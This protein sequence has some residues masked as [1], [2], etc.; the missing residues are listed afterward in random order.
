M[1]IAYFSPI[2]PIKSGISAYSE[3]NLLPY[4]S[5][6]CT[7]DLIIDEKF[8]P[9]NE[10]VKKKFKVISYK[11]FM[12][13]LYDVL[14]YHMGNNPYHEYIYNVLLQ[15]PGVVVLHD[16]FIADL[17]VYM[18]IGKQKPESYIEH[19]E[20]C[21]GEKG[22]KIA[23][24]AISSNNYPNF[25]YPLIKKMADSSIAIIVHS[26]FAK[27]IILAESPNVFIK[28]INMPIPLKHVD[29]NSKKTD[30]G[31]PS[32][33]IV[34]STFGFIAHHKRLHIVLKAFAKF[35]KTY[36]ESKFLIVGKFLEKKYQNEIHTIIKDLKIS[37]KVI[38]TGFVDN[39][40]PYV[41]I[42]DIIVQTRYPTAGE[43]SIITLELMA[44]AKPII[45]SDTGWFSEL[46]DETVIK[47]GVN[48]NEEKSI[49]D[50]FTKLTSDKSLKKGVG[51]RAL[52]YVKNEHD[53]EKISY[54]IFEFL[55]HL[56]SAERS[57]YIK[58]LSLHLH[59]LGIDHNDSSY[60]DSLTKNVHEVFS[61]TQ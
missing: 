34:I 48:E 12:K 32:N 29:S 38:E 43:T 28:K 53:P 8:S 9:S 42:S 58:N 7:I 56:T 41:E 61:S 23:E 4:L 36:P 3:K 54:E 22:R 30:F 24:N 51:S 20:Y 49:S 15:N 52:E 6:H 55:S 40:N 2:S 47:I 50:A 44:K 1:K 14:L 25:D 10:D 35:V 13:N 21:L 31:I 19:M 45:V 5:K 59:D 37:D 18:T 26:N 60:L 16:P 39:L 17:L 11:K 46:P 27:K 57:K 33:T